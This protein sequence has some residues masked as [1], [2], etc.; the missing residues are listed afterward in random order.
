MASASQVQIL[1]MVLHFC[2]LKSKRSVLRSYDTAD[3]RDGN[4]GVVAFF[5][6]SR[7]SEGWLLP[8]VKGS[9]GG[10]RLR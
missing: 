2:Y 5:D 7:G 6:G 10:R 1:F 4:C 9:V 8:L 3:C